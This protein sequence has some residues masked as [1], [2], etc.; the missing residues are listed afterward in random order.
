M[1]LWNIAKAVGSGVISAVVP[2]GGAII[3]AVNEMLPPDKKLPENATGTQVNSAIDQLPAEDQ[4]KIYTKQFDVDIT[5]IQESNSTLRTMLEFDTR[6]P[7]TTRPY[8]A[9]NSFHVI[10]FAIITI[11]SIWAVGVLNEDEE[12]VKTVMDGWPF[13]LA[14]MGPLVTLLWAYFGILKQEHSNKLKAASGQPAS[15]G[16]VG[17]IASLLKR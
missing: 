6:N 9:K 12:M 16:V 14:A 5:Q 8:I 1:N 17:V 2:G 11:I 13:I 10:G 3:A 15:P 7:H 4:V